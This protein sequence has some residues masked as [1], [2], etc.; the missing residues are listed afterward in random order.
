V[1]AGVV[2]L[3]VFVA[4]AA[5][6][7]VLIQPGEEPKRAAPSLTPEPPA[8]SASTTS[9]PSRPSPTPEATKTAKP[10]AEFL[11]R[12]VVEPREPNDPPR[13]IYKEFPSVCAP[14]RTTGKAPVAGLA[15]TASSST[16][17]DVFGSTENALPAPGKVPAGASSC[18]NPGDRSTYWVP[19]LTQGGKAVV[20][21]SFQVLYKAAVDDYQSVQPFPAGLR[22]L[23]GG[24]NAVPSA[25]AESA[26]S[27]SCTDYDEPQLPKTS[28]CREGD[29]L[30]ARI[31]APGCWDGR[32]L[33][34]S[35]HRSH[36][37][38]STAGGCPSSHPV[39]IPT[40][41]V[42]VAYPVDVSREVKVAGGEWGFGVVTG[43]QPK[44][45][46]QLVRDCINAGEHCG[47]NGSPD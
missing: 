31:A 9:T 1:L 44:T 6:V 29:R 15:P 5:V 23:T 28:Q 45:L 34:V 18:L 41:L 26:V 21:E 20:P 24:K 33:D 36:L 10:G 8:S 2:L 27:W 42:R 22:I 43:W 47:E 13:A 16:R 19:Q 3:V 12:P 25:A 37:A 39:A 38:W 14:V 7:P 4:V 17:Y 35:G 46:T 32:R 40:L 30:I 11:V